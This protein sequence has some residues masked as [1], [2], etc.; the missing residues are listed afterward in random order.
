MHPIKRSIFPLL[1]AISLVLSSAPAVRADTIF[2]KNGAHLDG[3]ISEETDT[4]VTLNVEDGSVQFKRAEI[5]RIDR[6][7]AKVPAEP[8]AQPA[9]QPAP[10][11]KKAPT[12]PKT[13]PAP[14]AVSAPKA[15][16]APKAAAPKKSSASGESAGGF[17]TKNGVRMD[18]QSSLAVWNAKDR[19]L[20]VGFFSYPIGAEETAKILKEGSFFFVSENKPYVVINLT[21]KEDAAAASTD[22]LRNYNIVFF[23]FDNG[24][25]AMTFSYSQ[26]DWSGEVSEL[27]G[28]LQKGASVRGAFHKKATFEMDK[29]EYEWDV[30][31]NTAFRPV[32]GDAGGSPA[33]N[34]AAGPQAFTLTP[35]AASA[36]PMLPPYSIPRANE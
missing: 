17:A 1:A 34:A 13:A 8:A 10:A 15:A 24:S 5:A 28:G 31:F 32:G 29:A 21:L 19:Q 18:A 20:S 30:R 22:S 14:K 7:S 2:L 9:A 36:T 16:P 25:G 27:A 3:T 35:T 12:V 23:N 4:D 6:T 33:Q 11:V 26:T